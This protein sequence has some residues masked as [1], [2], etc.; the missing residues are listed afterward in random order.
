[1]CLFMISHY[2]YIKKMEE[3]HYIEWDLK[4]I[5]SGDYT[6]VFE[7]DPEFYREWQ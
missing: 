5:T 7:L 6:V 3:N 2:D 4:T 1:M